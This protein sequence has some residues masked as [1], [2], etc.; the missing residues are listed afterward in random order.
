MELLWNGWPRKVSETTTSELQARGG[1]GARE[2]TFGLKEAQ[3]QGL[4]TGKSLGLRQE[5]YQ[6]HKVENEQTQ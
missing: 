2:E 6:G 5:K 3:R 1:E 4:K